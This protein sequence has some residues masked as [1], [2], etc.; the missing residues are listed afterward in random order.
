MAEVFERL[1][2]QC[3]QRHPV[4]CAVAAAV[5]DHLPPL[6]LHQPCVRSCQVLPPHSVHCSHARPADHTLACTVGSTRANTACATQAPDCVQS[7]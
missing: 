7:T 3:R 5:N 6:L 2:A 4:Q 1:Q